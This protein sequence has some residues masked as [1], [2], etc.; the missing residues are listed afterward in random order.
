MTPLVVRVASRR[1][2]AKEPH[3]RE[4][5]WGATDEESPAA[6]GRAGALRCA[7]KIFARPWNPVGRSFLRGDR[8]RLAHRDHWNGAGA[9]TAA[10]RMGARYRYRGTVIEV[11]L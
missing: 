10:I 9:R 6:R 2:S 3:G 7:G 1:V 4:R 8:R 11:P 5:G